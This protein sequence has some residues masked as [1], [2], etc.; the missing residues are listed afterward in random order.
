MSC[1]LVIFANVLFSSHVSLSMHHSKGNKS[2]QRKG[3]RV[4]LKI[5][6]CPKSF[7]IS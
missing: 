1:L 2:T 6:E 3:Y 5:E 7:K 4:H